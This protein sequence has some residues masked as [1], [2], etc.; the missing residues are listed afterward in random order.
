ML[1]SDYCERNGMK[2]DI[3]F[4]KNKTKINMNAKCTI[5]ILILVLYLFTIL[6][7][8]IVIHH[9]VSWSLDDPVISSYLV[10]FFTNPGS[11]CFKRNMSV[12]DKRN[13]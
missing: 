9:G 13:Y 7:G 1:R 8:C 11:M 6:I 12:T 5:Q 10:L 4:Y 3:K 2:G